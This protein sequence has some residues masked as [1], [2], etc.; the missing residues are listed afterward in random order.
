[1]IDSIDNALQRSVLKSEISLGYNFCKFIDTDLNDK[2]ANTIVNKL[3]NGIHLQLFI[4]HT[5]SRIK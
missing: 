2:I 4:L 3:D 5:N 1:M